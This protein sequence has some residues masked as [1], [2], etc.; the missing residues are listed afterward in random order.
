M[1]LSKKLKTRKEL[2]V[3]L[4]VILEAKVPPVDGDTRMAI[5]R[6][7]TEVAKKV[8]GENGVRYKKIHFT[9]KE[10]ADSMWLEHEKKEEPYI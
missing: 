6:A 1:Y 7:K 8:R 3:M 10:L 5:E 2:K 9:K 4:K